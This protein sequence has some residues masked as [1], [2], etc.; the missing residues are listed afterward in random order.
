MLHFDDCQ[1]CRTAASLNIILETISKHNLHNLLFH[2]D[3]FSIPLCFS[4]HPTVILLSNQP[5]DSQRSIQINKHLGIGLSP[6]LALGCCY[7][8]C[9][10]YRGHQRIPLGP[11]Q[12]PAAPKSGERCKIF[13]VT[14]Y[15]LL[16]PF[17][18][19]S[20]SAKSQLFFISGQSHSLAV[21]CLNTIYKV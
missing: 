21:K 3:L 19:L 2:L 20:P 9:Y 1:L 11:S 12:E 4:V 7:S 8:K 10:I 18:I 5:R 14:I 6:Q 17:K 15:T 13:L 16:D